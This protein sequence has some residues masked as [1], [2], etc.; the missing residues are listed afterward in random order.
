M[1]LQN[2][3]Q[4]PLLQVSIWGQKQP[5]K[6]IFSQNGHFFWVLF[7]SNQKFQNFFF[8]IPK[9]DYLGGFRTIFRKC[10]PLPFKHALFWR[11]AYDRYDPSSK[12]SNR[13]DSCCSFPCSFPSPL[14]FLSLFFSFPLRL[15]LFLSFPTPFSSSSFL[16]QAFYSMFQLVC[17]II[18]RH[19]S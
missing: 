9:V 17:N 13:G 18:R 1:S 8:E 4:M 5:K 10:I 16:S 15:S 2:L 19:N 14:L 11:Y 6:A 7:F 12:C 3:S